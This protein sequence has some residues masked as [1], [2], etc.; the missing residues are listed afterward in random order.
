MLLKFR[1]LMNL[2]FYQEYTEADSELQSILDLNN[3]TGH[4]ILE[5]VMSMN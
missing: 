5:Q 4:E 3:I 1:R 2:I